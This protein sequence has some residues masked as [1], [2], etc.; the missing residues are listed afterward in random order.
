MEKTKK[1]NDQR[2]KWAAYA[3]LPRRIEDG[4][5]VSNEDKKKL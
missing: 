3:T 2:K 5:V 4:I 1:K